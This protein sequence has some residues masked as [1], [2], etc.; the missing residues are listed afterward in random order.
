MLS[1]NKGGTLHSLID[2]QYLFHITHTY[3]RTYA[4]IYNNVSSFILYLIHGFPYSSQKHFVCDDNGCYQI[5]LKNCTFLDKDHKCH[6]SHY[7]SK[8][9]HFHDLKMECNNGPLLQYSQAADTLYWNQLYSN[10][11]HHKQ[12]PKCYY[13]IFLLFLHFH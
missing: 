8:Q 4:I 12:F 1:L 7:P 5:H 3:V 10:S 6:N 9:V 13:S 2:F 11:Y